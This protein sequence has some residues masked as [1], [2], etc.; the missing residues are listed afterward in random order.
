VLIIGALL[1]RGRRT[2]TADLRQMGVHEASNFGLYHH[3][4]NRASWSVLALS[5]HLL[6]LLVRTFV[7]AGGEFPFVIDRPWSG[8][9]AAASTCEAMTVI[10]SYS[11]W[12]GERLADC[13]PII[14]SC[15][16]LH[17]C[18]TSPSRTC[19]FV[20]LSRKPCTANAPCSQMA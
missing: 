14:S 12:P 16:D 19:I 2:V 4:V 7:G 15:A 6:L 3:V 9:G 18:T 8:A 10:R 1:A 5:R 20:A 13:C 11:R 17:Q